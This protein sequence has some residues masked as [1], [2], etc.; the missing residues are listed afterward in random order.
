MDSVQRR[1]TEEEH[2]SCEDRMKEL[3]VLSLEKIRLW[4]DIIAAFQY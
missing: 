4:G 1:A 2:L 3:Q